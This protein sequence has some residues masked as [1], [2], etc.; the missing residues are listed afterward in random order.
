MSPEPPGRSDPKYRLR[1]FLDSAGPN[2]EEGKLTLGTRTG[3]LHSENFV[4]AA[5][6]GPLTY[7]TTS[8]ANPSNSPDRVDIALSFRQVRSTHLGWPLDRAETGAQGDTDWTRRQRAKRGIRGHVR[9][10][11]SC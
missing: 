4:A 5:G 2:S 11:V 1:R 7:R 6:P 3:A 9:R 8:I 10:S